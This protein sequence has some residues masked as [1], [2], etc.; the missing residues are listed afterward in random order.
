MFVSSAST[1]HTALSKT[2]EWGSQVV[3]LY[4]LPPL[5]IQ[6]CLRL[7]S[8][9]HKLY[10]CVVCLHWSYSSVWDCRV[11]F[12]SCMFVSFEPPLIQSL[13]ETVWSVE[14]YTV[15]CLYRLPPLLIELCLRLQSEVHKL[16]VCIVCLHWSYSSV[17]DCWVR[18]TSCMFV[19]SAST[20]HTAL[21]E[22]VEWGS[23]VMC[24][25]RLPPLIIQL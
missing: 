20:D 2:V 25:Y 8:E 13:P 16:Y 22:T 15:V 14:V 19:S 4:R 17:W 10:V 5:I 3:C 24:L 6:L 9:V 7:Q 11:T 21:S 18:F 12:T 23:Q 1:D